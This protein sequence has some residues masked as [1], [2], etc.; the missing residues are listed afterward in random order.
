M[1]RSALVFQVWDLG[2]GISRSERALCLSKY[3]SVY[4][5]TCAGLC[6][7]LRR[8][9]RLLLNLAFVLNLNLNLNLFPNLNLNL[10][11]F[12]M[13]FRKPNQ[14]SFRWL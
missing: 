14:S 11:L 10:F 7:A 8:H 6:R 9:V 12:Q 4:V 5:W 2:F 1:P 3:I 13:S